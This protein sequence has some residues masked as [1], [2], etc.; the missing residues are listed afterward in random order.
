MAKQLIQIIIAG[1]QVFYYNRYHV[2]VQ[3][4]LLLVLIRYDD[5]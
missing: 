2:C 4:V 5:S 1:S 3:W